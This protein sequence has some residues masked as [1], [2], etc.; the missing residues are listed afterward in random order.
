MFMKSTVLAAG[1]ASL[2]AHAAPEYP[3]SPPAQL[4]IAA[5]ALAQSTFDPYAHGA[6]ACPEGA[7][8]GGPKCKKL[9]PPDSRVD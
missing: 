2:A 8:Y 7:T 1:L 6:A 3:A 9:I 5:T 4:S